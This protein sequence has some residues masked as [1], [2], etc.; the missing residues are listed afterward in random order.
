MLKIPARLKSILPALL[1]F[2][3]SCSH[4]SEILITEGL[5]A[6]VEVKRDQWG[7]NHIYARNQHDLF[8]AQGYCAARDRLFQFEIWRRQAAGNVAEILGPRE[9]KRDIGARLFRFRGDMTAEMNHYHPDGE[10][11]IRAFVDGINAC[12]LEANKNPDKLPLEF[13][14]L[15]IQPGFWTPETVISR[16]QGLLGNITQELSIGR[17]VSRI[18]AEK[19]K[20]ILWFHPG[21]P[22]I[23]ID[24]AINSQL[25]FDDVLQLYNTYRSDIQFHPVDII[26]SYR[27]GNEPSSHSNAFLVGDSFD[28]SH[29]ISDLSQAGSNNWVI[30]GRLMESGSAIMANDPHRK[31]AVPSLRY[32]VHLSAP[33]WNVI[34]GGEP[35]IPG[36]S[37]GHN[38]NGAW[39]L[40]VFSTDGEDLYVYD[41]NPDNLNQYRYMDQWEEMTAQIETIHVKNGMDVIANLRFT[42][43]GPVTYIDSVH[44]KA[45]A[46]RCAWLEPGGAPYLASL[47][48]DQARNWEEFREA[49]KYNHIPGENMIWTGIDGD[50]GW[51]AVGIAPVRRNF[52]GLVPVPGSGKYE[53]DGYLPMLDKPHINNPEPG[54][55]A[56]ANQLVIPDD[57]Q[58]WEA[59][60]FTWADP[61]RG[62][63]INEVL[64]SGKKFSMDDMKAL[65]TDYYSIPARLLIPLLDQLLLESQNLAAKELLSGWN[66]T[67]AANSVEAGIY[68]AWENKIMENAV[69]QFVPEDARGLIVPPLTKII[70][71]L[72]NPDEKFG[73][74]PIKGRND[75]LRK[76]FESAVKQLAGDLGDNSMDWVYGQE[77]YKHVYIKHPLSDVVNKE[78]K[79]KLNAGPAP[80]GGNGYTPGATGAGKNQ[81]SGASFRIIADTGDWDRT[82]A[83][84]T[85]GQSGDPGSKYYR[86]LFDMWANDK[87]FPLYYSRSKVEANLAERIILKP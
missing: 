35:E 34:G 84:N 57:Y 36:V 28:D 82:F 17:A 70:Q 49:C 74:D 71:W 33:G 66:F 37:I 15:D 72:Q 73:P 25:L 80:R 53:W 52:S 21:D 54:F 20:E 19:V 2:L 23:E 47:R 63:R 9:I 38:E 16:H 8:F 13:K 68:S 69:E 27:A 1:I 55:F 67:L 61:F 51:Q 45:Y 65:Q 41:L 81:T 75:F 14:L 31:I 59:I 24:P 5:R 18:G 46:V 29:N 87:Y 7:I 86:N 58:H 60:G 56:T 77:R 64:G 78:L 42:R 50:I 3:L 83:T 85:P 79:D 32:I 39:G 10:E 48:I 6:E 22:I 11:I 62:E 12:I 26:D 76:T 4:G 43:H 30:Q 44:N 40:T